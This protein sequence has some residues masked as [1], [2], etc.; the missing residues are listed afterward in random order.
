MDG[1]VFVLRLLTIIGGERFLRLFFTYTVSF[2][3]K[4]YIL[5]SPLM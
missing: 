1:V 2:V 5:I 3:Y 4:S